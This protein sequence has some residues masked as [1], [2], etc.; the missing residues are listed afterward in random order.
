MFIINTESNSN[1]L[2]G[3]NRHGKGYGLVFHE[4]KALSKRINEPNNHRMIIG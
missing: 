4:D 1:A 3:A 2:I